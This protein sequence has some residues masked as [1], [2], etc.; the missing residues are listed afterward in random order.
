MKFINWEQK[1]NFNKLEW[2]QIFKCQQISFSS[3]LYVFIIDC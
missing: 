2:L 3:N 1:G